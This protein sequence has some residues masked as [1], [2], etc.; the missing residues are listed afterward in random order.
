MEVKLI[1]FITLSNSRTGFFFFTY[2]F[3][4]NK[5]TNGHGSDSKEMKI[6]KFD[7]SFIRKYGH[8]YIE[9]S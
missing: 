5:L 8:S 1:L 3:S 6:K 7:A 2:I 9:F 4:R